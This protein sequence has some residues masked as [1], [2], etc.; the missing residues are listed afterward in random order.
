MPRLIATRLVALLGVVAS[1]SA[2]T[3]PTTPLSNNIPDGFS[4]VVQNPAIPI[5]HNRIMNFRAN[6]DDE[7]LVLRP[8]GVVTNDLLFLVNGRLNTRNIHAVIDLEVRS[9]LYISPRRAV[10]TDLDSTMTVMTPQRC[11]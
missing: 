6:G 9:I 3:I 5:V 8:E 2:C 7:H 10:L 11:S 1:I 4:I